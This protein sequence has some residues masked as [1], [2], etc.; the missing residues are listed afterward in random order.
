MNKTKI[1]VYGIFSIWQTTSILF[2]Q[3]TDIQLITPG[4][5]D[6][7]RIDSIIKINRINSQ[8]LLITFGAD[9]VTAI[10]TQNGIVVVDAGISTGLTLKYKKIIEKE[11]PG[12]PF[13]FVINT[14]AH[15]DHYGGNSVFA[16]A[17]VIAHKNGL[18]EIRD[19]WKDTTKVVNSIS[20]VAEQ[21]ETKMQDYQ[22]NSQD[23]QDAFIQKTRYSFALADAQGRGLLKT[24]DVTFADSLEL[25]VGDL[26]FEL[27]FFGKCHSDSDLLMYIPELKTLF[28]G[29]L[30]FKYG[31]AGI[32]D[33]Q[34]TDKDK[35]HKAVHWIEAR[36]PEIK[37]IIGG[38]GQILS[39]DDLYSFTKTI[40][41]KQ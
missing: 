5:T 31:R 36:I 27:K 22:A 23:W 38:H 28:T 33:S 21:Y 17:A 3:N 37:I 18:A 40:L 6:T 15:P 9:A 1:L 12:Q 10:Q 30:V 25:A 41:S 19:Q 29:D 14:H 7:N 8:I 11:F 4:I 2:A 39:P 32:T 24:P 35:W 13:K 20:R 26:K 16:G 34:M